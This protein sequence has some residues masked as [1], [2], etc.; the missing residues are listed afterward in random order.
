MALTTGVAKP[1][2]K[3]VKHVRHG[4]CKLPIH[5]PKEEIPQLEQMV[6]ITIAVI[7]MECMIQLVATPLQVLLDGNY[8]IL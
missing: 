1:K 2:Q 3:Q 7:Q 4:I 6:L 5:I 8:V